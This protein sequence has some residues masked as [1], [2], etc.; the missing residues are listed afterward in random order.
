M[1]DPLG[2]LPGA[3]ANDV[4]TVDNP[5]VFRLVAESAHLASDSGSGEVEP[6]PGESVVDLADVFGYGKSAL[7]VVPDFKRLEQD[8]H[9]R[10]ADEIKV[11]IA[12]IDGMLASSTGCGSWMSRASKWRDKLAARLALLESGS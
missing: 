9:L 2:N 3:M 1:K 12:A 7:V 6:G 4:P 11:E 5:E 8:D 10:T